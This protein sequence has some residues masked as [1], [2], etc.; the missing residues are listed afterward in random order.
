MDCGAEGAL[1]RWGGGGVGTGP[2]TSGGWQASASFPARHWAQ[3]LAVRF[4][5]R[6]DEDSPHGP[7]R[8]A[9]ERETPSWCL[10]LW[11]GPHRGW[12]RPCGRAHGGLRGSGGLGECVSPVEGRGRPS[13]RP[14][15][16]SVPLR[17]PLPTEF[18]ADSHR[19]EP[20]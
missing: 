14:S 10:C 12:G 2:H 4:Q 5:G 15:P 20:F 16:P 19:S 18:V 7:H 8:C 9:G 3:I 6:A 1:E 17:P 11:A 13:L